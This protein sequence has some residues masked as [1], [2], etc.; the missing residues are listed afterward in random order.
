MI[1]SSLLVG[2]LA[3]AALASCAAERNVEAPAFMGF[4]A[5]GETG[6]IFAPGVVSLEGQREMGCAAH[7]NGREFYF[8]RAAPAGPDVAIWVVR[9]A[10]GTLT[11][12]A[13]VPFSG[14][15]RDFNPFVTPDGQHLIFYRMSFEDAEAREGSWIA[16]RAG[17]SWG[18]PRYL[19]AEYCV[20]TADMR[21]FYFNFVPGAR[22]NR[23]A[24][25]EARELGMRTLEGGVFS[26]AECMPGAINSPAW[27]AHG[28]VSPDGGMMLFDSMRP[29]GYGRHDMY[30]SF[31][32]PDG[33][34]GEALNLG[35]TINDGDRSMPALSPD[36][37]FLFF[38][39]EGDIWWISAAV[40]A[41]LRQQPDQF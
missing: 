7:P 10:D 1:R 24:P 34:W 31:R 38:S 8:C 33:T 15:Y 5:P 29:G 21:T 22:H 9:E 13:M 17:D 28:C 18:E 19:V 14:V 11:D 40:L 12:P 20:T 37:R 2:I 39:A 23:E 4:P 3:W 16:D 36:G 30:V 35:E 32:G 6:D 25:G 27:D 41:E 26:E